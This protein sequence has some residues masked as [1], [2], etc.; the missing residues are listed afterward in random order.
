[1]TMPYFSSTGTSPLEPYIKNQAANS[2]A[3]VW[4]CPDDMVNSTGTTYNAFHCSYSMNE[5]LSGPGATYNGAMTIND[6]DSYYPRASDGVAKY[7]SSSNSDQPL[8]NLDNPIGIA[9]IDSPANTDLLFESIVESATG[10][11]LGKQ[12][13]TGRG[14]WPGQKASGA[15]PQTRRP[16]MV[17]R[18]RTRLRRTIRG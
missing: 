2:N 17:M 3:T 6:P 16:M 7:T 4:V 14:A 11:Y 9:R 15:Q 5:F 1:M 13:N 10:T 12:D 18:P 8:Q